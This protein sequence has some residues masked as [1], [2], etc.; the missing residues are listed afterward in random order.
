[1]K[2]SLTAALLLGTALCAGA[3]EKPLETREKWSF[4]D[5]S[6]WEW[7]GEGDDTVL[8]LKKQSDF[9]PKVRS[10]FNLAWFEGEEW[11]SFEL[12]AEVR[13]DLFNGGNNDVCIAFGKQD[14][15]KFYYAHLGEN[16]DH[17]HLQLHIV[18][19]ADRKKI[20]KVGVK[21]LPWKEENWHKVKLVRDV[22]AGT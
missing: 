21:T 12:T 15:T 18:N 5:K 2:T 17:V 8:S 16:A 22:E 19:D 7:S 6:A 11:G 3:R 9:K 20:T 10:P 4:G 14:E 13:L 1:M